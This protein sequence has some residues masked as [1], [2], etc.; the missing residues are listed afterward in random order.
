MTP[1]PA[2]TPSDRKTHATDTDPA[3]VLAAVADERRRQD[4]ERVLA[5]MREETGAGPV[6][7]GPSM[8]GFGRCPYTTADGKEREWFASGSP[9]ARRR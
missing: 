1:P 7:W 6:V 8:I 5:L 4:A 3:A 2:A 9:P